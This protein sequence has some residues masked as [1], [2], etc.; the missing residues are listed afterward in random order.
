MLQRAWEVFEDMRYERLAGLSNGHPHNL[1][2]PRAYVRRM[3]RKA[4]RAACG[5]TRRIKATGIKSKE[6]II[7]TQSMK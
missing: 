5:R 4:G 6:P 7:S 3:G 1:R 2:Q